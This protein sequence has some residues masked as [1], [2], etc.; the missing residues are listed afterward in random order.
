MYWIILVNAFQAPKETMPACNNPAIGLIGRPNR[1][2]E[3]KTAAEYIDDD[4]G[5][6]FALHHSITE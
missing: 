3:L 1:C 2:H 5:T 4:Q 6:V